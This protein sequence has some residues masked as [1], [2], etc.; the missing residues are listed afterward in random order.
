MIEVPETGR[1]RGSQG[2]QLWMGENRPIGAIITYWVKDA[3]RS[4]RQRR[5][6]ARARRSRRKRRRAIRRRQQLTAE[7]DEE[8]PQTLMTMTDAPARWCAG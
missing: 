5:Q 6:D 1:R 3:P 4:L 7:A 8:A 2:E